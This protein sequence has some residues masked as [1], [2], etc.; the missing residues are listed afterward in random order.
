MPAWIAEFGGVAALSPAALLGIV[1]W[2]IFTGRLI[3]LREHKELRAD[4]D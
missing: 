1:L 2:M 3:T 4:R